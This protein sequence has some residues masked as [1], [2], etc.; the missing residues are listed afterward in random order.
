MGD[1]IRFNRI[2]AMKNAGHK[3]PGFR[4]AS[5]G[6]AFRLLL[7]AVSL[8]VLSAALFALMGAF[9]ERKADD[10]RKADS[11]CDR[12]LQEAFAKLSE[13]PGFN[14][15]FKGEPDEG[16]ADFS[17]DFKRETRGDTSLLRIV[18]TGVSGSVTQVREC[19][20]RLEVTGDNDSVW[21]NEGIR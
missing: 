10:H 19:T 7:C 12:G 5:G 6:V 15:G 8:A 21:V 4:G 20:L 11:Q 14:E 9:K 17:V 2:F 16:G 13:S 1:A 3:M 18:S